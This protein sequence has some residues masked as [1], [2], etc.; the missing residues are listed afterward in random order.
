MT[1]RVKLRVAGC[2][3][4]ATTRLGWLSSF[5]GSFEINGYVYGVKTIKV[6]KSNNKEWS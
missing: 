6:I 4:F 5:R 3:R 2:V 1:D